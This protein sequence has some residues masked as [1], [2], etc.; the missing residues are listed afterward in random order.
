MAR[1]YLN[2]GTGNKTVNSFLAQSYTDQSF[3]LKTVNYFHFYINQV[4][5]FWGTFKKGKASEF[6]CFNEMF[7][8]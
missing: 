5:H 4:R 1:F 6:A 8:E 7:V 2:I 3:F